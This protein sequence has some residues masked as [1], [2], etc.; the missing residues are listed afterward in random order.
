[1]HLFVLIR[2]PSLKSIVTAPLNPGRGK[3]VATRSHVSP[4]KFIIKYFQDFCSTFSEDL[5]RF[6][7]GAAF[8]I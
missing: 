6:D 7:S 3:L 1:M 2:R 4:A 8:G 5:T